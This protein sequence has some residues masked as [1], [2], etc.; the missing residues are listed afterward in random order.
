MRSMNPSFLTVIAAAAVLSACSGNP[1]PAP[2]HVGY[3]YNV[4]GTYSMTLW[5]F[6]MVFE[7]TSEMEIAE[8]GDVTGV[9]DFVNPDEVPLPIAGTVS[10]DTLTFTSTYE[11]SGGC[12]GLFDG[13]GVIAEGGNAVSGTMSINDSCAGVDDGATFEMTR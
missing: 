10:G 4:S 1:P 5:A 13:V 6:E 12:E 3:A 2:G 8:T 11:R 9:F 7:G